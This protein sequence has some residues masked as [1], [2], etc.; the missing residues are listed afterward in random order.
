MQCHVCSAIIFLTADY[1]YQEWTTGPIIFEEGQG[2]N[3][4]Y[5]GYTQKNG[6]V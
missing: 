5:T 2:I 6:A 4:K 1:T 3:F